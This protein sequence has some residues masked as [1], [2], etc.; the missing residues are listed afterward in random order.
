MRS[1]GIHLI[2]KERRNTQGFSL[3]DHSSHCKK[4]IGIKENLR[5]QILLIVPN[6]DF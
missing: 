4:R 6:T 3:I 2:L 5:I 1:V